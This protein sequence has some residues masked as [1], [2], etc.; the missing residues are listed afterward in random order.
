MA[1]FAPCLAFAIAAFFASS[2]ANGP[3]SWRLSVI[4]GW[5]VMGAGL[6]LA[7]SSIAIITPGT[8]QVQVVYGSVRDAP[9]TKSPT[10]VHPFARR[11]SLSTVAQ[12]M[13]LEPAVFGGPPR[14]VSYRIP[15]TATPHIVEGFGDPTAFEALLLPRIRFAL[16]GND[17]L[18]APGLERQLNRDLT[19]LS[20][21]PEPDG[22]WVRIA[23]LDPPPL[24]KA[25]TLDTPSEGRPGAP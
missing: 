19:S 10:L 21:R 6:V 7:A 23:F 22:G 1:F 17:A 16:S 14:I 25:G 13:T 24:V 5:F 4:G 12:T 18:D 9:L 11:V 15:P 8:A 20:G 3:W 2:L